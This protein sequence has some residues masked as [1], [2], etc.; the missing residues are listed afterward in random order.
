MD[1]FIV[2]LVEQICTRNVK[3]IK[4]LI[5]MKSLMDQN[6]FVK[7]WRCFSKVVGDL[8]SPKKLA[9]LVYVKFT[10]FVSFI[11]SSETQQYLKCTNTELRY[12][13]GMCS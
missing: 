1:G 11:W 12:F 4:G 8:K 10:M 13:L 7:L 9:E 5:S 2:H 3:A 6:I